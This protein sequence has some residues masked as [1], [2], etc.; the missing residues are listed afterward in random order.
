MT[1]RQAARI[2]NRS[3]RRRNEIVSERYAKKLMKA[4]AIYTNTTGT[5]KDPEQMIN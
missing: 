5:V 2:I 4:Y 3:L 1:R